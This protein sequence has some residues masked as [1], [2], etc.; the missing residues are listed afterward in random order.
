[1]PTELATIKRAT[2]VF[3]GIEAVLFVTYLIHLAVAPYPDVTRSAARVLA[4]D[5]APL[6]WGG[7]VLLGL[8]VPSSY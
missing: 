5:L 2:L 3:L 8:L 1:M 7:L 4:G 6:F